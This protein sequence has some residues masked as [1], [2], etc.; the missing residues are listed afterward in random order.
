MSLP[1]PLAGSACQGYSPK[2]V[3]VRFGR[4]GL[5]PKRNLRP[6]SRVFLSKDLFDPRYP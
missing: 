5:K 2:L 6:Q 1:W 4:F 3:T